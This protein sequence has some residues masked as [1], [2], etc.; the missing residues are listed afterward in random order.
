[1]RRSFLV[2]SNRADRRLIEAIEERSPGL[3]ILNSKP[4]LASTPSSCSLAA[5][6]DVLSRQVLC[7]SASSGTPTT[8]VGIEADAPVEEAA[9][10]LRGLGVRLVRLEA[11]R[12][13]AS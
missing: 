8:R 4:P 12:P 1:M 3:R 5:R 6:R 10:L 13:P 11:V 9:A 7:A 2:R